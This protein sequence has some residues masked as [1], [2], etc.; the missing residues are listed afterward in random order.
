M[1]D[2]C[3]GIGVKVIPDGS[4]T[5]SACLSCDGWAISFLHELFKLWLQDLGCTPENV[6]G[7][8]IS[9]NVS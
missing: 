4:F 2:S 1:H 8:T 6:N 5:M 9:E 3:P 7:S